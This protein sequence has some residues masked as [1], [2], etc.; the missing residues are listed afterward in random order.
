MLQWQSVCR[1][2]CLG[3]T[4]LVQDVWSCQGG[5]RCVQHH[6]Q[7]LQGC[8]HGPCLQVAAPQL[9]AKAEERGSNAAMSWGPRPGDTADWTMIVTVHRQVP[10]QPPGWCARSCRVLTTQAGAS[11]GRPAQPGRHLAGV[12][13][14]A[15]LLPL[16]RL[17]APSA[18]AP[19][20]RAGCCVSAWSDGTRQGCAQ[21][22]ISPSPPSCTQAQAEPCPTAGGFTCR[23]CVCGCPSGLFARLL[24]L[25]QAN[26]GQLICAVLDDAAAVVASTSSSTGQQSS[27]MTEFDCA[28]CVLAS[29]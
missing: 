23:F 27:L 9:H 26:S 4:H 19:E 24:W 3:V 10:V 8:M 16:H 7:W 5:C 13:Q 1:R 18:P 20:H 21:R 22:Q 6:L 17:S 25:L 29:L 14:A 11:P 2:A 12:V 15:G 28:L